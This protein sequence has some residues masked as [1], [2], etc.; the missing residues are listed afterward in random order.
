MQN[1]YCDICYVRKKKETKQVNKVLFANYPP[2]TTM[3]SSVEF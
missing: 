1:K 2:Y 3:Y